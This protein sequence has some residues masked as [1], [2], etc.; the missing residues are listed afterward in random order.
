MHVHMSTYCNRNMQH[1]PNHNHHSFLAIK[2]IQIFPA[3]P[4]K[5]RKKERK[6]ETMN[7]QNLLFLASQHSILTSLAQH[8]STR[9]L[10]HLARANKALH[11][12]IRASDGVFD[13]LKAQALCDGR[14]LQARMEF[15]AFNVVW[16]THWR[17]GQKGRMANVSFPLP[18]GI[19][20]Y[21]SLFC[22][23]FSFSAFLA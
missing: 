1:P 21:L 18:L 10:L 8:L 6:K 20:I 9:D 14:G 13:K 4:H 11:S 7:A 19:F 15:R 2:S 12:C 5:K 23:F 22:I 17:W 3:I 16:W